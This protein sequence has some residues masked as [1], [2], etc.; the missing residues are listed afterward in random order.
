[1][2]LWAETAESA[3]MQD[4]VAA[5]CGIGAIILPETGVKIPTVRM[6]SIEGDWWLDPLHQ[7]Y[8]AVTYASL[9]QNGREELDGTEPYAF[10]ACPHIWN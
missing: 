7:A 4:T 10:I 5:D 3:Q 8:A 6:P 1:L 9:V 2:M